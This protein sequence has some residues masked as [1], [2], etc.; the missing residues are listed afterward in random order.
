MYFKLLGQQISIRKFSD[1]PILHLLLWSNSQEDMSVF[2]NT[3]CCYFKSYI[4][5][6]THYY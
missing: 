6:T 3:N 1:E 2:E 5:Y 4:Q